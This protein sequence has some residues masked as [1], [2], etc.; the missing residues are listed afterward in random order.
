M[1][2]NDI[3]PIDDSAALSIEDKLRH[4]F[5][6]QGPIEPAP[7]AHMREDQTHNNDRIIAYREAAVLV[8]VHINPRSSSIVLTLRTAHLSSHA[9]Q[10]SFPGGT[11]E[12]SDR[13]PI[14]TALRESE[15]EI[16]LAA[17]DVEILGK[18]GSFSMPSGYRITPVVG[19]IRKANHLRACPHEVAKIIHLPLNIALDPGSY[20]SVAFSRD[21]ITQQVWE[22]YTDGHRV[23]GATASILRHLAEELSLLNDII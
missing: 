8:P 22:L 16:G 11:K 20:Q 19:I 3:K 23:W 4:Y 13:N 9:G 7:L 21:G 12:E 17:G 10:V 6:R 15:E 18:L 2:L 1:N 14:E 5:D